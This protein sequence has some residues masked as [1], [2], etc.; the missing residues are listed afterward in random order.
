MIPD[1]RGRT[2]GFSVADGSS[3][4]RILANSPRSASVRAS[5]SHGALSAPMPCSAEMDP[6]RDATKENTASS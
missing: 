3:A 6:P 5:G 4:E 1:K 2:F